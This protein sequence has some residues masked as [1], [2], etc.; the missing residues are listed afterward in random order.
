MKTLLVLAAG[1]LQ[2]P[3]ITIAKR[4]GL[5]VVALDGDA[6]APGLPLA[7]VARVVDLLD[8]E[9]C[10]A[11]ARELKPDGV[12]HICSEVAMPALGAINEEL[13]LHGPGRSAV[14]RST[15]KEQMR[16]AFEAGGAPSPRSFG[17][18]TE[19]EALA[20]ARDLGGAIILKPSRN[21]GS[22]GVT[23]IGDANDSEA[24]KRAFQR[25]LAESRDRG[26]V[27]EEF[28]SGP[29]YSVEIVAW[30]GEPQVLALTDKET[31]GAPHF[32]ETGHSQ[33]ARVDADSRRV[34][35]QAA[36]AGVKALGIDWSAAHAE[37]RLSSRGPMLIEIGARLGGDFITTELVPRSTGIDMV[38]AAIQLALGEVPHLRPQHPP[39]GAAIRY[40]SPKPGRVLAIEGVEPARNVPGVGVVEV[41]VGVG[42]VVP[43]ITSS[44]ARVGHVIAEGVDAA[45]AIAAAETARDLVCM[46]TVAAAT[47]GAGE[48]QTCCVSPPSA[49]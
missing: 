43:E 28:V 21:S 9:A 36:I 1:R 39:Q 3:A 44:L 5:R 40:L 13:G 45:A 26:V 29:E 12:I 16:R 18:A 8:V 25:A 37:V 33:P 47:A 10:L 20:A 34:I 30:A 24:V 14:V 27:V 46:V 6:R 49:Q 32:V 17:A 23:R 41:D 4:L 48:T 19:T 38:E 22:R 31:T 7:D 15:N 11:V 35:E 2:L 42:G